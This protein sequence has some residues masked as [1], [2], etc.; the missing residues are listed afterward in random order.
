M[1][2]LDTP[3]LAHRYDP[4]PGRGNQA[5]RRCWRRKDAPAH[6]A[7]ERMDALRRGVDLH[8]QEGGDGLD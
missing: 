6:V 5:C 1:P 8:E 3:T 4:M 7:W 2:A